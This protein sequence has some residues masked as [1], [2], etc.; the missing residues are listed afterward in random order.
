MPLCSTRVKFSVMPLIAMPIPLCLHTTTHQV[1][2]IVDRLDDIR[3]TELQL[4]DT[5][6]DH[7]EDKRISDNP[8]GKHRK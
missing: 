3:A 4:G 1:T 6:P 8:H 2:I 5:Y 7:S